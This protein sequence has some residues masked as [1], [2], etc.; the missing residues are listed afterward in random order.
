MTALPPRPAERNQRPCRSY[1]R[2][3][4]T[5]V[6]AQVPLV[7]SRQL[8]LFDRLRHG[9][10]DVEL[11]ADLY[12]RQALENTSTF[13]GLVKLVGEIDAIYLSRRRLLDEIGRAHV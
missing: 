3:S 2:R 9:M 7:P 13:R 12:G 1:S 10:S 4:A 5:Q 8:L 11:K 6:P